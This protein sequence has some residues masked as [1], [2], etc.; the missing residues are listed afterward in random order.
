MRE[1][2]YNLIVHLKRFKYDDHYH[3]LIKFNWKIAFSFDLAID[4][5]LII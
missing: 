5:V 1:L 2:P 3:R 4:Q